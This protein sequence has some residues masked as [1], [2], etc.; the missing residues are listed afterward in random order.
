MRLSSCVRLCRKH[1]PL[2]GWCNLLV[3]CHTV[4]ALC[5][6]AQQWW[7]NHLANP[8]QGDQWCGCRSMLGLGTNIPDAQGLPKFEAD[9]KIPA[10]LGKKYGP[11]ILEA[12]GFA[13][14]YPGG[15]R[16][17]RPRRR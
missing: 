17:P 6:P 14:V 1:S 13:Q 11:M 12:D 4:V 9:G 7:T 15:W 8:T 16:R 3:W 10:D 2:P 5:G